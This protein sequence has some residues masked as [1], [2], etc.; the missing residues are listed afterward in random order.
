MNQDIQDVAGV[1]AHS[2]FG[3]LLGYVARKRGPRRWAARSDI[4][5]CDIPTLLPH[6]WIIE[7]GQTER[8]LQVR[9]AGTRVESVYGRSLAGIHLEDLDWGPTSAPIF[10]SLYGMA[11]SGRGHF[12]D[13]AARIK[14]R[15]ARRVQRIGLPLSDDGERI[16]HLVLL[17]LYEFARGADSLGPEH[18]RELW[19]DDAAMAGPAMTSGTDE[20]LRDRTGRDP[21]GALHEET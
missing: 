8:R 7:V 1:W 20:R 2:A 10:A 13:T 15:L 11:E 17:A 6:L 19:L 14:P 9:L 18:F 5:P 12:L 3:R 4:D 16:S 21:T